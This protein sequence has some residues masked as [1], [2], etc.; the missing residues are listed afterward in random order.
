MVQFKVPK[1]LSEATRKYAY[2]RASAVEVWTDFSYMQRSW[3]HSPYFVKV[4]KE[5]EIF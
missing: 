5:D 1:L 3:E 4:L 2:T